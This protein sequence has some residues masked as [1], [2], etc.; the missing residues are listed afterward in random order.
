M[1]PAQIILE[2]LQTT[3]R[4]VLWSWG[5]HAYKAVQSN[6]LKESFG[7]HMGTLVFKVNGRL[8][9]G[10]VAVSLMPNDTYT[11]HYGSLRKGTFNIQK[12]QSDVYC[13]NL[14]ELIDS[15]VET[16]S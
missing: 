12:S 4:A 16:P 8:R 6:Q 14:M 15:E 9:K 2:Q 11:V 10:H 13:D 5:A 1:N 7:N 3:N